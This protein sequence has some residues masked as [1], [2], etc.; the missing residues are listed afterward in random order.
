MIISSYIINQFFHSIF[1]WSLRLKIKMS[2]ILDEKFATF[3]VITNFIEYDEKIDKLK[4]LEK[5]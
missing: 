2:G 4:L 3:K 1:K 5:K